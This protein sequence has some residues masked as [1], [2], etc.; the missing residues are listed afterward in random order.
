MTA[1]CRHDDDGGGDAPSSA[2]SV[3]IR[4]WSKTIDGCL[5][6]LAGFCAAV[7]VVVAMGR[8][9]DIKVNTTASMPRGLWRLDRSVAVA[10]GRIVVACPPD[11]DMMRLARL[12]AYVGTGDC[13]GGYEPLL[14][15]VAALGGAL[16]E[17]GGR[18]VSVDG[19]LRPN[20]APRDHDP[21][22]RPVAWVPMARRLADGE[23]WLSAERTP[24]SFD[25]RYFGPARRS[26]VMGVAVP[27]LVEPP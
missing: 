20:S 21:S 10:V 24:S 26:A 11:N 25:S 5:Y 15:E 19:T 23:V 16:V 4:Q 13:P 14:K 1:V 3:L 17:V 8:A 12:R 22:G 18:G 7:V 6:L 9:F 2:W 27:M